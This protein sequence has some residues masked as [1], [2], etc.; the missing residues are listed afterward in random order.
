VLDSIEQRIPVSFTLS[1]WDVNCVVENNYDRCYQTWQIAANQTPPLDM[2]VYVWWKICAVNDSECTALTSYGQFTTLVTLHIQNLDCG[3]TETVHI[4]TNCS[5]AVGLFE[6]DQYTVPVTDD[7]EV[8]VLVDSRIYA[9]V[10]STVD[11][12]SIRPLVLNVNS[13]RMCYS[14]NGVP[15]VPY[16]SAS[17]TTTGC[18]TTGANVSAY[19][20][21]SSTESY[22]TEFGFIISYTNSCVADC[23]WL[24]NTLQSNT[25]VLVEVAWSAVQPVGLH[26]EQPTER[27]D[28][29]KTSWR[30]RL[31][32][33]RSQR[34]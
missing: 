5:I 17:P 8:L 19:L 29:P 20:I 18:A 22:D 15:L 3:S 33:R 7:M 10:Q 1:S 28:L 12:C 24:T 11:C 16:D 23:N 31:P 26:D 6:D 25:S 2:T 30:A 13:V 9:R 21:Y 4:N 34:S 14:S 27:P 32:S